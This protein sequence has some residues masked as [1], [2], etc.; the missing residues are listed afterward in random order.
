MAELS[1]YWLPR[2]LFQR[3]LGYIYLIA[4]LIAINQFRPLLG[5]HGLLPVPL[6]IKQVPFRASPSLFYLFPNDSAFAIAAWLGLALTFLAVIGIS[7][8]YLLWFSML[9]W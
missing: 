7:D 1:Q 4:F 8:Q 9:M 2:W 3:G 5:E 6:F